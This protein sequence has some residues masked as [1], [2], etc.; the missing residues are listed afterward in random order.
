VHLAVS[1]DGFRLVFFQ[2]HPEY[3]TVSLLK[4]YQREVRRFIA[5]E[6]RDYPPFPENYLPA[7]RPRHPG[8]TPR[9][10][11]TALDRGQTAPQFPEARIAL[12]LD[13]TWHDTAEGVMGNW[14][15]VI[16]QLTHS[17][18]RLPFMPGVDPADPL[19]LLGR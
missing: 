14:M 3:D 18:R 17:D 12:S 6:R 16:Y 9:R 11:L 5:R 8:G 19:R 15:G 7:A 13:N 10:I 2:G 1:E 4:E